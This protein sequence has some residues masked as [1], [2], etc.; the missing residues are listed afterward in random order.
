M[1][2]ETCTTFISLIN[3]P[4]LPNV[5]SEEGI[6]FFNK[7]KADFCRYCIEALHKKDKVKGIEETNE[8]YEEAWELAKKHL[9]PHHPTRLGV[10]L[11]YAVFVYEV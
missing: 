10:I 1:L 2:L 9:K 7:I 3:D 5:K 8:Y 4:I 11:N 6:V